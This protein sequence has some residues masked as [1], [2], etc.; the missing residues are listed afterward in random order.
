M[1]QTRG[2]NKRKVLSITSGKLPGKYRDF[3]PENYHSIF[4]DVEQEVPNQDFFDEIQSLLKKQESVALVHLNPVDNRSSDYKSLRKAFNAAKKIQL[5]LAKLRET[6]DGEALLLPWEV[7]TDGWGEDAL[8]CFEHMLNRLAHYEDLF[9]VESNPSKV[10][11]AFIREI[12]DVFIEHN[13]PV[14][15]SKS[16]ESVFVGFLDKLD[17][18]FPGVVFPEPT[19]KQ[20]RSMYIYTALE[21][22]QKNP[23][24]S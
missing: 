14:T 3:D 12:R 24:S 11:H 6:P 15:V 4:S 7:D 21:T 17:D 13:I 19:T 16:E 5:N 9:L 2:S 8:Q 20:G 10:W 22:L 23:Q 1:T 18:D